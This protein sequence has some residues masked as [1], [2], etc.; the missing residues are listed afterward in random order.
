MFSDALRSGAPVELVLSEMESRG[1]RAQRNLRVD[2]VVPLAD[3][4]RYR[5]GASGCSGGLHG[6]ISGH[7]PGRPC[8]GCI[9]CNRP[10]VLGIQALKKQDVNVDILVLSNGDGAAR[11][12][13]CKGRACSLERSRSH[14]RGALQYVDRGDYVS[15]PSTMPYP[16][17][18]VA[19]NPHRCFGRWWLGCSRGSP[20]P[21][22]TRGCSDGCTVASMDTAG[23]QVVPTTQTDHVATH[24]AHID[25]ALAPHPGCADCRRCMVVLASN[26][27]LRP[28]C[29]GAS[30][31]RA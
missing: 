21:L 30:L 15:L 29:A 25:T 7:R 11:N 3:I 8:D 14:T 12:R 27:W 17:A 4:L 23:Q 22:A 28:D 13:M 10:N 6:A 20:N 1:L 18:V 5:S 16:W 19:S 2:E 24:D 9:P 31:A 26:G